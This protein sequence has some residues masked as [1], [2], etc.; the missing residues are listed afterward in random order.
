MTAITYYCSIMYY[1]VLILNLLNLFMIVNASKAGRTVYME[2][3]A[4]M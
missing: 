4:R 3:N 2:L 1:S